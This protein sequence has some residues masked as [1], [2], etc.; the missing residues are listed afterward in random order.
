MW[1][2]WQTR[3]L[4]VLVGAIPCGFK[5]RH[6]HHITNPLHIRRGFIIFEIVNMGLKE[7]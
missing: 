4:Q 5:S 6:L 7:L 1:W 2:N 3:E